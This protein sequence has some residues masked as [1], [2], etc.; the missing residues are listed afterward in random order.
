MCNCRLHEKWN[1]MKKA[2]SEKM[3]V[4]FAIFFSIMRVSQKPYGSVIRVDIIYLLAP[5]GIFRSINL[6]SFR[7]CRIRPWFETFWTSRT[8][9]WIKP[10]VKAYPWEVC[11]FQNLLI[12]NLLNSKLVVRRVPLINLYRNR[13]VNSSSVKNEVLKR[14]QTQVYGRYFIIFYLN[15]I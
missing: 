11:F 7:F 13:T 8:L 14:T 9:Q 5:I 15:D 12:R 6:L 3:D 4:P 2:K 10:V 1:K